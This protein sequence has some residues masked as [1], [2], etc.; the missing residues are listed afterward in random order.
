MKID[1]R[2]LGEQI[3]M[4]T[5]KWIIYISKVPD[6]VR[7]E[8]INRN[9]GTRKVMMLGEEESIP[10]APLPWAPKKVGK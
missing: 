3:E 4:I 6:G 7:V 9:K 8:V 10:E 5:K 1:N 2:F